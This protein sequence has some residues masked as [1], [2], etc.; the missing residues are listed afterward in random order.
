MATN[1]HQI[2]QLE[3][4]RPWPKAPEAMYPAAAKELCTHVYVDGIGG[5]HED[6]ARC[7]R[8][9]D[10]ID[11]I[12]SLGQFQIKAWHSNNK[13]IDQTD[14]EFTDFFGHTWNKTHEKFSFKKNEFIADVRNLTKRNCLACVA[15]L[16]DPIGL[17]TPATVELRIDLQCGAQ[18][19]HGM[20]SYLNRCK[21]SGGRMFKPSNNYSHTSLTES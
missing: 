19:I 4:S 5:F 14:E 21:R 8:I 10:E 6:K 16:W 15:Q 7:K 9:T 17:V 20:K 2:L 11:A 12:L 18:D 3:Q 1:R 13:N